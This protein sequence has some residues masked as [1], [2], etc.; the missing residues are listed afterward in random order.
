LLFYVFDVLVCRGRS[1][2]KVQLSAKAGNA[3]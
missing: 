1:L 3:K 2:L